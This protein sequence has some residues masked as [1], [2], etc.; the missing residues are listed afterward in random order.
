M[1]I[2]T[3][4]PTP[5]VSVQPPASS[6]K[7]IANATSTVPVVEGAWVRVEAS[8]TS[9][10]SH[11]ADKHNVGSGHLAGAVQSPGASPLSPLAIDTLSTSR[12]ELPEPLERSNSEIATIKRQCAVSLL[13][14]IPRSVARIFFGVPP[15][16]NP[17][18]TCSAATGCS[19]SPNRSP[20]SPPSSRAEQGGVQASAS[21]QEPK[22]GAL[23]TSPLSSSATT[24]AIPNNSNET[25]SQPNTDDT[26][27]L[28]PEELFL[29][30]TIETDLLDVLA[31]EYCNKH[32]VYSIIETVLAKV[33]PEMAERTIAELMEDRGV[34][35]VPATF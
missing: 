6:V 4:T 19:P 31:D 28:D 18:R 21:F 26:N 11:N 5:Q 34:S 1:N 24:V 14:V 20:P 9:A 33:L 3:P 27:Q 23:S 17:D 25:T 13:A 10:K 16:S 15:S 30:E 2:G 12:A 35:P 22:S 8:N 7:T 32:L 29:L